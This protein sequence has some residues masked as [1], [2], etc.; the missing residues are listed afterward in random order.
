LAFRCPP[1]GSGKRG[2][3]L[4]TCPM[5]STLLAF[6]LLVIGLVGPAAGAAAQ[7][8]GA[9]PQV[10]ADPSAPP[11]AVR[12]LLRW[13]RQPARTSAFDVSSRGGPA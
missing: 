10:E 12:E 9:P 5:R 13:E 6:G 3:L 8:A 11:A 2:R 4:K 1:A 7:T